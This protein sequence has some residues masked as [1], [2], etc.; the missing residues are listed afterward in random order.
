MASVLTACKLTSGAADTDE[1]DSFSGSTKQ[2]LKRKVQYA[3]GS[4]SDFLS[5]PRPYKKVRFGLC[6]RV[7]YDR[8]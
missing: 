8:R 7:S 4:D 2:D 6:A 5:D 3:R 1:G